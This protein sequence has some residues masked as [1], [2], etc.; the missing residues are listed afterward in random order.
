MDAAKEEQLVDLVRDRP[1]LWEKK[2]P[3]FM[4]RT[5]RNNAWKEIAEQIGEI[6]GNQL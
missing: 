1:G 3:D 2:H 4:N 5:K 6:N